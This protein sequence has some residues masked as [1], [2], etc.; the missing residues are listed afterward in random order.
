VWSTGS[1]WANRPAGR[2]PVLVEIDPRSDRVVARYRVGRRDPGFSVERT[3]EEVDWPIVV[4][5]VLSGIALV[6]GSL[7]LH[8]NAERR[9]YRIDP[10]P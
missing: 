4:Q 2:I 7:W 8:Q 3:P 10:R 9:L 1:G 5:R 6:D